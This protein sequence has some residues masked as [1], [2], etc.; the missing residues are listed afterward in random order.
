MQPTQA[1][2]RLDTSPSG[3]LTLRDQHT[4][5]HLH[6]FFGPVREPREVYAEGCRIGGLCGV[7]T[8]ADVGMGAGF[9]V[10]A[11]LHA[12]GRNDQLRHLCVHSFDTTVQGLVALLENRNAFSAALGENHWFPVIEALLREGKVCGELP[13]S[14]LGRTFE[15]IFHQ[16]DACKRIEQMQDNSTFNA[17]FY[18][19]FS[20]QSHPM[21]WTRKVLSLFTS[22]LSPDGVFAT[23]SSS[24]AIRA[25][26]LS[27][28]LF[29]GEGPLVTTKLRATLASCQ[30]S[31]L[32][33]PL[34][35]RWL[36]RFARSQHPFLEEEDQQTREQ[37]GRAVTQHP[38]F[39]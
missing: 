8:L 31:Q 1:E 13:G 35:Q 34:S 36:E 21:L 5:E 27:L 4:G 39:R 18:D 24:T 6:R 11:A 33:Q 29:V 25:T 28:N 3:A 38:Q 16:G 9:N 12:A 22:R 14:P 2:Y 7:V 26:L 20:W 17:I 32:S 37:I 23:Y 10:L 15:W 19:F 30:A